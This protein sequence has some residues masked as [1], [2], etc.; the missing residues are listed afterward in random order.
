MAATDTSKAAQATDTTDAPNLAAVPDAP[1]RTAAEKQYGTLPILE[2]SPVFTSDNSRITDLKKAAAVFDNAMPN[3]TTWVEGHRMVRGATAAYCLVSFELRSLCLTGKQAIDWA[4][5][6]DAYATLWK[7]RVTN[8]QREAGMS[9]SEISAFSDAVRRYSADNGGLKRYIAQWAIEHDA[10]GKLKAEPTPEGGLKINSALA[11]EMVKQA[12]GQ[13]TKTG[14]TLP[15]FDPAGFAKT[16][17]VVGLKKAAAAKIP[18]ESGS[19]EPPAQFEQLRKA[20]VKTGDDKKTPVVAFA[21]V[22]DELH[23]LESTAATVLFPVEGKLPT[24]RNREALKAQWQAIADLATAVVNGL[25]EPEKFDRARDL[26]DL[27]WKQG[28]K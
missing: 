7:N 9:E 21:T 17:D 13:V 16:G 10:A 26:E 28:K 5:N 14:K 2:L 1:E 18:N 27:L 3:M 4:G 25:A 8:M 23:H 11:A 15:G 22:A 24:P 19:T 6:T 12:R 20:V